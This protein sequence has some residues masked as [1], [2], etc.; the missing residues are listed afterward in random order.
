MPCN[1][2]ANRTAEAYEVHDAHQHHL[3]IEPYAM[4]D[5]V[6]DNVPD[7][8]HHLTD[9][10]YQGVNCKVKKLGV[11]PFNLCTCMCATCVQLHMRCTHTCVRAN[12]RMAVHAQARC[13][14]HA[15]SYALTMHVKRISFIRACMRR[16][17]HVSV[18]VCVRA[19][20]HAC[21]RACVYASACMR[22]RAREWD[23]C[24]CVYASVCVYGMRALLA[25]SPLDALLV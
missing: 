5:G 15:S 19:C 3:H 22:L 1:E 18:N 9:Q 12:M 21:I 10:V 17:K 6:V 14:M 11:G 16:C 13:L 8:H 24:A 25:L 2:Q 4:N 20:I 23:V 7:G